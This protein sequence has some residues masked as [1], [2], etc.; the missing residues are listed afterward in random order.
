MRRTTRLTF[1]STQKA[2]VCAYHLLKHSEIQCQGMYYTQLFF[3]F[4]SGPLSV[5]LQHH[6]SSAQLM[7]CQRLNNK[8]GKCQTVGKKPNCSSQPQ[9]GR[10]KKKKRLSFTETRKHSRVQF[11]IRTEQRNVLFVFLRTPESSSE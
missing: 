11:Y 5:F 3:F 9:R 6:Y 4:F 2:P 10:E 1:M 7:L 8:H